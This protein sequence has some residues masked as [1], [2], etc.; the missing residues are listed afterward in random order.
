MKRHIGIGLLALLACGWLEA[1]AAEPRLAFIDLDRVFNEYSKTKTADA[2]LKAQADEFNAERKELIA[3]Y[4]KLQEEFN[5]LRD[6]AQNPA[7]NVDAAEQKKSEA[8]DKLVEIREYESK[9]RRFDES[10]R[11]QLDDQSRRMR[12]NIVEEMRKIIEEYARTQ[13]FI[14]VMDSSGQSLNGVESL[15]YVDPKYDITD[16]I[17]DQLNATDT[18]VP[19]R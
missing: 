15:L 5:K 8:E 2:Q 18:S 13:G 4:E 17:L 14:A 12:K 1:R 11:K 9:I 7:L 6:A 19:T 3:E 16:A 10:R